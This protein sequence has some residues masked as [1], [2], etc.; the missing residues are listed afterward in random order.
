MFS[1]HG[2]REK[3]LIIKEKH[4]DMCTNKKRTVDEGQQVSDK[5]ICTCKIIRSIKDEDPYP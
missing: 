5:I 3:K 4:T 1:S 2:V